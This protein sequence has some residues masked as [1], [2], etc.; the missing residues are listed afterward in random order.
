LSLPLEEAQ[1]K[2]PLSQIAT[3]FAQDVVYEDFNYESAMTNQ[4]EVM[5]FLEKFA[6]ITSLKF[7]AERFSDGERA[8]CFTWHV[9]IAGLS[10]DTPHIRGISFY[11][12]N[13]AGLIT[14]VRDIPE[15][16]IK[17]PP[18]QALAA[19]LRPKLRVLQPLEVD[20]N[21]TPCNCANSRGIEWPTGE[22]VSGP[23]VLK[24]VVT[25]ANGV[26]TTLGNKVTGAQGAVFVFLRHLG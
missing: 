5:A 24:Q 6:E 1:G 14:Y 11:E 25:D 17:P 4:A 3:F 21:D 26:S 13:D 20:M 16:A 12:L 10:E 18:L 9:E 19:T 15:S 8:C 22:C 2:A 7:V 23:E